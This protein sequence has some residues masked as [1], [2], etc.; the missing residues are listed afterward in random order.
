M[1]IHFRRGLF[2]GDSLSLILFCLCV[3]PLSWI[4]RRKVGYPGR[5][6]RAPVTHLMLMDDLK[7]YEESWGQLERTVEEVEEVSEAMGMAFGLKKCVVVSGEIL[8]RG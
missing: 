6:Q 4:L 7:V 8:C 2:Q 3:A 1:P 5:F